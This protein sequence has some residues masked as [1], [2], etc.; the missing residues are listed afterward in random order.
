MR[1]LAVMAFIMTL[2]S[3]LALAEDEVARPPNK[4]DLRAGV[5]ASYQRFLD[6]PMGDAEL[7]LGVGGRASRHFVLYGMF[8]AQLGKLDYLSQQA[9]R[10]GLVGEL[11]FDRFRAGLGVGAG[12]FVITRATTKENLVAFDFAAF[13]TTSFDLVSLGERHALFVVAK[14]EVGTPGSTNATH[15]GPGLGVGLRY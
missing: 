6:L 14:L 5:G 9:F 2:W 8:D 13:G 12:W 1:R 7:W 11:V 10:F 3:N 4:L 15:W